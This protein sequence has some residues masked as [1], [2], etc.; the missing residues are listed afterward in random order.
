MCQQTAKT[1]DQPPNLITGVWISVQVDFSSGFSVDT[2]SVR[3]LEYPAD[4]CWIHLKT[5]L[6]ILVPGYPDQT[7]GNT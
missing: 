5:W 6:T 7:Y 1:K 4:H 3:C 2:P